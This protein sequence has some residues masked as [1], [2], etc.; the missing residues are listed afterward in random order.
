M[1]EYTDI[2]LALIGISDEQVKALAISL[3]ENALNLT[4]P[5]GE[6]KKRPLTGADIL[7]IIENH[8]INKSADRNGQSY[9]FFIILLHRFLLTPEGCP[10]AYRS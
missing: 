5:Q 9:Y 4:T 6:G 8:S 7:K 10:D 2:I 3:T 1:S